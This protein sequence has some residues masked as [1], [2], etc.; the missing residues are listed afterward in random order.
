MASNSHN[1]NTSFQMAETALR[2]AEGLLNANPN[3]LSVDK[4]LAQQVGGWEK[5]SCEVALD[6]IIFD[7]KS[8]WDTLACDYIGN[9]HT[10]MT[11]SPQSPQYFIEF[12]HA[13]PPQDATNPEPRECFYRI[14]A[15]G[16]GC[17]SK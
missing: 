9:A 2:Q 17:Q 11:P 15:R 8:N 4:G 1:N 13:K 5:A 14:T 7:I 6:S 10:N 3:A 16:Y 12:L